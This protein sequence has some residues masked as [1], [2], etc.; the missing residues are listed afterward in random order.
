MRKVERSEI[1]D[2]GTYESRRDEERKRVMEVKLPRRVH[3]GEHLTFLFENADTV[4]YQVHEM[5][6]AEHR[7]DE[8]DI[9]HELATYNE[10]LGDDGGLGCTLLIEI[11]DTADRD[12]KLREWSTLPEH[13]WARLEGGE[14][15]RASY[16]PRQM[17]DDR[18][19][20]V[21]YLQFDTKGRVPVALESD[22]PSLELSVEL[23]DEQ[24]EALA[25][26]LRA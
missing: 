22:H 11:E 16:D 24:R 10:I 5:L 20:S 1:L 4:R 7:S 23:T 21:Q 17:G 9:A 3:L 14:R 19:S 12:R 13:L 26:D 2:L 18:L 15:V 25:A 6:R 8:A